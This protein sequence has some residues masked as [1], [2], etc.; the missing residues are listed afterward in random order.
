M[1]LPYHQ[2]NR[3]PKLSQR[4]KPYANERYRLSTP[5]Q[6]TFFFSHAMSAYTKVIHKLNEQLLIIN[7]LR[8]HRYRAAGVYHFPAI[9]FLILSLFSANNFHN[10]DAASKM[11]YYILC[12]AAIEST[13]T[14]IYTHHLSD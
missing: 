12:Q 2:I 6:S 9:S 7:H 4:T 11:K 10:V 14:A 3:P 13:Y 1:Y 5:S 8:V